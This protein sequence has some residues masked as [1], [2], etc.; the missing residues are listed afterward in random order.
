MPD[1]DIYDKLGNKLDG[2]FKKVEDPSKPGE[3]V[4]DKFGNKLDGKYRNVENDV[5]MEIN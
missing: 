1:D 2:T 3:E 4:Y 5:Y